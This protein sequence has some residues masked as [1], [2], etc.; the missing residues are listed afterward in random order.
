MAQTV[1][2]RGFENISGTVSRVRWNAI[3][4]GLVVGLVVQALLTLL[5]LAI[6]FNAM[7]PA[8]G[9]Y[10][11]V[12]IGSG[13][14]LMISAIISTYLGGWVAASL[15][16]VSYRSD[17]MIHGVLTWGMLMIVTIYLLGT[18]LGMM[19]GGTFNLMSAAVTGASQGVATTATQQQGV[20]TIREQVNILTQRM[21]QKKVQQGQ[22][23]VREE[24]TTRAA[25]KVAWFAFF[26]SLLSLLAGAF[27]GI[28]GFRSLYHRTRNTEVG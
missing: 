17:G 14:W 19:I 5:G 10:A 15:A 25:A 1:Y 2:D 13:I 21:Q 8:T 16:N 24:Q 20:A 7:N 26:A 18:S 12:G 9:N 4:A 23:A 11:G 6:G 28:A 22:A 3:F 27:G